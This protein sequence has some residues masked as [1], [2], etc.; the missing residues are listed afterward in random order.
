MVWANKQLRWSKVIIVLSCGQVMLTQHSQILEVR[1][2]F[3]FVSH[4]SERILSQPVQLTVS[5]RW[6]V[7]GLVPLLSAELSLHFICWMTAPLN[8]PSVGQDECQFFSRLWRGRRIWVRESEWS[9]RS[10]LSSP[11]RADV[12][13]DGGFA[14]LSALGWKHS[15]L[16]FWK[17]TTCGCNQQGSF[18]CVLIC[19]HQEHNL[20]GIW[21]G[22]L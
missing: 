16:S 13:S 18:E 7:I 5:E 10:S 8:P 19:T 1:G 14:R 6:I 4:N 15:L 12:S 17:H 21:K 9:Q 22:R 3:N 2:S 11:S 20:E